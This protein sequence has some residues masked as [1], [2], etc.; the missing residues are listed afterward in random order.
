[1]I[2]TG[3]DSRVAIATDAELRQL[4]IFRLDDQEYGLDIENV[5]QVVRMV[6]VTKAPKAPHFVEGMLNLRGKV[7]PVINLRDR[8]GLQSKPVD[9]N[10]HLLI[11][12]IGARSAG[13]IVDVV[14]GVLSISM[15]SLDYRV[16]IEAEMADF[17]QAVAKLDNR[18][19]IIL[20]IARALTF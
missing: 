15:A 16:D 4:L 5:V 13:L 8:F 19:I 17:V 1:M 10:D 9:L 20:D 18:L 14:L 12:Q 11:T 6:A 7:I 3:L 2:K